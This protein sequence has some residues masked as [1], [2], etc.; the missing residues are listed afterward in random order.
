MY[1]HALLGL[2]QQAG[3][4]NGLPAWSNSYRTRKSDQGPTNT[5]T[6]SAAKNKNKN[7]NKKNKNK[8][9]SFIHNPNAKKR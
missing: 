8:K 3:K 7:K 1:P 2:F 6:N 5:N 9:K 4:G